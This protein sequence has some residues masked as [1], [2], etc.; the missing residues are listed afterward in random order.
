MSEIERKQKA[1][2]ALSQLDAVVLER[3]AELS[4]NKKALGFFKNAIQFAVLKG[5]LKSM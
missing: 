2:Q 3:L 1:L 4:R 5:Y